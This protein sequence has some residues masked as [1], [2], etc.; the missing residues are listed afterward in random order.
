MA[1]TGA[2]MHVPQRPQLSQVL[3]PLHTPHRYAQQSDA[4]GVHTGDDVHEH[5][6]QA[7]LDE[8]VSVPYV[9]HDC[10]A[11]GAQAP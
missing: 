7:Q 10:V 1:G 5:A 6:P 2:W 11:F 8:H 3:V 9:L 4:P